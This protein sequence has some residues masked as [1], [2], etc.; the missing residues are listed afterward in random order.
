MVTNKKKTKSPSKSEEVREE[1]V[2][3]LK[4]L[5]VAV[6][7]VGEN[8]ILRREGE[9][10]TVIGLLATV[11]AASL[12]KDTPD[13]LNDIR[14]LKLK[15]TKGR[16]KDLKEICAFIE[17]L[18]NLVMDLQDRKKANAPSKRPAS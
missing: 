12:K 7:E 16:L 2:R 8:F 3:E 6:R 10:E 9:I 4:H 5:R 13:L 17:E 1:L 18:A 11:P 15:P 14:G